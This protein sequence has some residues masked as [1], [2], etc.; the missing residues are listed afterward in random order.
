MTLR[1]PLASRARTRNY[2][3]LD[4]LEASGQTCPNHRHPVEGNSAGCAIPL[5]TSTNNEDMEETMQLLTE[6]IKSKLPKLYATE[7]I[8]LEKKVLVCKFFTPDSS[9]TWYAVEFDGKDTFFG[10]VQGFENEWGYFTLSEL[11]SVSGPMGLKI[12]RDLY[13]EPTKF[14][15]RFDN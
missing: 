8:P 13:W 2:P 11:E 12:E 14:G 5:Y 15:E 9:W 1:L 3:S 6:E 10:Y 4:K 7:G